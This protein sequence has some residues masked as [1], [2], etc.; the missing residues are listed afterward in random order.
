MSTTNPPDLQELQ[1]RF[2]IKAFPT[3]IVLSP[4]T[5]KAAKDVGYRGADGTEAWITQAAQAVRQ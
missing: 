3:L 4:A 1:Q 2:D 5:G